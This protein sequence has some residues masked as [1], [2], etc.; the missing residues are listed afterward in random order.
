LH[1]SRRKGGREHK[2]LLALEACQGD[3]LQILCK[4][5]VKHPVGFVNHHVA[6]LIKPNLSGSV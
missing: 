1:D 2:G 6:N 4:S 5:Q 3:G